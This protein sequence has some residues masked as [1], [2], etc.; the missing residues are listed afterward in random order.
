LYS[1][2]FAN[3]V[4][5][6][7]QACDDKPGLTKLMKMLY[8]ADVWH[9]REHL[10]TISGSSYVALKRGPAPD[11]WRAALDSMEAAGYIAIRTESG[12]DDD[13]SPKQT[14]HA[15]RGPDVTAFKHSELATIK[16]VAITCHGNSGADLSRLSHRDGPWSWAW[17][18]H[19]P[20]HQIPDILLRW[21]EN[22]CDED[23]LREA[24]DRISDPAVQAVLSELSND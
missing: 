13:D 19:A 11:G 17:N 5:L 18:P 14:F 21:N 20:G 16:A 3:T 23:D 2:K 15:R 6:L 9:Y 4:L 7:L 8:F 12:Y 1:L 24:A 10:S 22:Q